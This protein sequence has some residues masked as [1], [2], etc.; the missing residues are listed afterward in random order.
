MNWHFPQ[1]TD[2]LSYRWETPTAGILET[3]SYTTNLL[4]RSVSDAMNMFPTN[5]VFLFVA[6]LRY[7]SQIEFVAEHF[8]HPILYIYTS[9]KLT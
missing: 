4:V 9:G 7:L 1:A 5:D 2:V 6:Y 8:V 3:S